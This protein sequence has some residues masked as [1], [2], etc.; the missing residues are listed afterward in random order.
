[1]L[2][3][4]G[5]CFLLLFLYCFPFQTEVSAHP[6]TKIKNKTL[7][8]KSELKKKEIRDK[9]KFKSKGIWKWKQEGRG[10]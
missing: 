6:F 10:E 1:M 5:L 7:P 3:L 4:L 9:K 8:V 2:L